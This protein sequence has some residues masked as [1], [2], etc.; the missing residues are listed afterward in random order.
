MTILRKLFV[1]LVALLAVPALA[2]PAWQAY[3]PK[4]FTQAQAAGKT[5]VVD[6]HATWCTTCRAQKPTLEALRTEPRLK[7]AVFVR[8]DF[9][10][11]RQFLRDH[12][13]PRQ[14]TILVFK[15]HQE[16]ARSVAETRPAQLRAAVLG[17]V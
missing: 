6:V 17:G 9:D 14:S 12:R 5:I 16:T 8:V 2:N 10:T 13:I 7:D 15:G 3:S 11:D 1:L 4:E